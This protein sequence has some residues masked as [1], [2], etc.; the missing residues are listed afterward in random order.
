MPLN[1]TARAGNVNFI[2]YTIKADG[3]TQKYQSWV[4]D[5]PVNKNNIKILVAGGRSR[6]KIENEYFNTLKNLGYNAEHN[7]GHGDQYASFNFLLFILLAFFVHQILELSDP[8]Y[9][10]C[11]SKFSSRIEY[12]NQLR[13][14]IRIHIFASYEQLLEF[15]IIAGDDP[16]PP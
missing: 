1:G 9:Q 3:K 4:T 11:R 13:C 7:Y 6:W 8:L 15:I 2:D 16:R 12:W 5:I 10:K 14:T